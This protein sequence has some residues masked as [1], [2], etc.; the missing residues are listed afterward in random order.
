MSL[1]EALDLTTPTGR[2]MAGLLSVFAEFE[3]KILRE[4]I[5]EG[6]GAAMRPAPIEGLPFQRPPGTC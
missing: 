2:A 6:Y 5:V 1:T 4:R 3:H